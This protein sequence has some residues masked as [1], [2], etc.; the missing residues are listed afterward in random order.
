[1]GGASSNQARATATRSPQPLP[2]DQVNDRLTFF[3]SRDDDDDDAI[4]NQS[5]FGADE[6][7]TK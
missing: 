2:V 1:L 3:G 7:D 5:A 4:F 6:F